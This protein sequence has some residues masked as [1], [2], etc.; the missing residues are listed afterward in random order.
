MAI[1][2]EV[3]S[4]LLLLPGLQLDN[5]VNVQD[6]LPLV[7]LWRLAAP[8]STGELVHPV[9]VD[10]SAADYVGFEAEDT[11]RWGSGELHLVAV[12]QLQEQLAALALRPRFEADPNELQETEKLGFH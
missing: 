10:A 7:H 1:C 9:L 11:D 2:L 5:L 4:L 12:A 6:P 3:L 8:D